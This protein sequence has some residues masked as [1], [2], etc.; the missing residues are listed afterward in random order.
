MRCPCDPRAIRVVFCSCR[1]ACGTTLLE[2]FAAEHRASLRWLERD[3]GLFSAMRAVGARL[4][5]LVA[6]DRTRA[7][8]SDAFGLARLAALGL[9]PE[10]L[11]VEEELFAGGEEKLRA[12][13]DALEQ[14]VLE[15]HVRSPRPSCELRGSSAGERGGTRRTCSQLQ[16]RPSVPVSGTVY[17]KTSFG[18]CR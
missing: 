10:L 15:F 11:V 12:A 18:G 14:P 16:V 6:V 5:F 1:S 8:R 2:A 9:I 17:C 3:G 13:I 4:H 7:Y